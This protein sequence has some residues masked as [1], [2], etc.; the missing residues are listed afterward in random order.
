[1][2]LSNEVLN[3][4]WPEWKVEEDL[5]NGAYGHV[6][7]VVRQDYNVTSCAAVKVISIPQDASEVD[8]LQSE[9]LNL[10]AT[11]T[12]FQ[13]VVDSFVKEIQLMESLKG[14]QNIVSV[15]DYKVIEKE[16]E[17]GWTIFIRMELLKPLKKYLCDKKLDETEVIKF[18]C[19]ICTAL[20]I[21]NMRNI[22]HRDIKYENIFVNDFGDFKLGDFGVA[23]KLENTTGGLSKKGTLMYMAPE[24][25]NDKKYDA[26]ADIYSLG[27]VLYRLLNR[28]HFP[29]L[30]SEKQITN[31]EERENALRRRLSGEAL[32]APCDASPE[33]ADVILRA[34]APNPDSR[35]QAASEM[36]QALLSVS[37]GAYKIVGIQTDDN[38]DCFETIEARHAPYAQQND[39]LKTAKISTFGKPKEKKKVLPILLLTII[40]LVL[41]GGIGVFCAVKFLNLDIDLLDSF[42]DGIATGNVDRDDEDTDD[43]DT[44][45]D[46]SMDSEVREALDKAEEYAT[47]GDHERALRTV[48]D[49]LEEFPDSEPLLAR[50]N[51]YLERI[52]RD[53]IA[54]VI[55][56]A[57]QMAVSGDFLEAMTIL[58]DGMDS[59]GNDSG[60]ESAY[61]RY[62]TAYVNQIKENAIPQAEYFFN[63]GD[64]LG[65]YN[66]INEALDK[67]GEVE[68]L[69]NLAKAYED[70]YVEDAIATA[71]GYLENR[72]YDQAEEVMNAVIDTFPSNQAANDEVALIESSRP[73]Y[74]LDVCPPYEMNSSE[75]S[76]YFEMAGNIYS[77]GLLMQGNEGAYAI[78]N[79]RGE[80]TTLEFELGHIDDTS[81]NS[82]TFYIY[83]DEILVEEIEISAS[84][85]PKQYS[86][87]LN[88]ANQ[89]KI[90][91]GYSSWYPEYG[92]ANMIVY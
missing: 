43:E 64:Y 49:A 40:L 59:Y 68:E 62:H 61:E 52:N 50:E 75:I 80:Y 10:D 16:N 89:L 67:V 83:I 84:S 91:S 69:E 5:G 30:D 81:M 44:D 9:G 34:C 15:E 73:K 31:P 22:I 92:F 88:G 36:H 54:D 65:A 51:E 70:I 58:E 53:G 35:F 57:D 19:D 6:Y 18:G 1:M 38:G 17:I 8:T 25:A 63:N 21:C 20:E 33:M 4:V 85:L 56:E 46:N 79:L 41:A 42:R 48:Q 82:V 86:I 26:R 28:D 71:N 23:R 77:N 87:D 37:A 76:T 90:T 14:V 74:L 60:L 3:T 66:T 11:R 32:P 72:E 2:I 12:Y 24:V 55:E 45:I 29:L 47:D 78:F 27:I 13:N 39:E 7:K